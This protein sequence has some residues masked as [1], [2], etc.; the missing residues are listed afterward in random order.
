MNPAD[1][2]QSVAEQAISAFT[3]ECIECD[4]T[5]GHRCPECK[6]SGVIEPEPWSDPVVGAV[7]SV[8]VAMI[9]GAR[10][11]EAFGTIDEV[12]DWCQVFQAKTLEHIP[13]EELT[14]GLETWTAPTKRIRKT[15]GVVLHEGFDDPLPEF[16]EYTGALSESELEQVLSGSGTL[17]E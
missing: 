17:E 13:Q 3:V 9:L 15:P 4:G 8:A 5:G 1:F 10:S 2:L 11:R 12:L 14:R 16:E 6:G 7:M